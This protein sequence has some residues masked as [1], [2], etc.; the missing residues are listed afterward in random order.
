VT[1]LYPGIQIFSFEVIPFNMI[2]HLQ[3][4]AK[5]AYPLFVALRFVSNVEQAL[6]L[7]INE[8]ENKSERSDLKGLFFENS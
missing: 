3:R 7:A 1:T 2:H 6:S 8:G 4:A 5:R